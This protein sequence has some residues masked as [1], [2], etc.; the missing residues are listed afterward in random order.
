[1]GSSS[2]QRSRVALLTNHPIAMR[3]G[4][5]E[6]PFPASAYVDLI[7]SVGLSLEAVVPLHYA[8]NRFYQVPLPA[9]PN[10]DREKFTRKVNQ[11]LHTPRATVA[12]FW[13]DVDAFRS[14][15][16]PKG[17]PAYNVYA[18]RFYTNP[19]VLVFRRVAA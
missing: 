12:E 6:W 14:R 18:N 8:G 7:E 9:P 2:F 5:Y 13:D 16:K 3:Y 1:M 17:D 10:F 4:P 19:Q 15:P 11:L